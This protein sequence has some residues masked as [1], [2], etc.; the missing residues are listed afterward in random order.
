MTARRSPRPGAARR[1]ALAAAVALAVT[2]VVACAAIPTSGPVVDG[3][4]VSSPGKAVFVS[5]DAPRDGALPEQ[6]VRGFLAAQAQGASSSFD[7]ATMFLTPETAEEWSPLAQVA[8]L[9]GEPELEVDDSQLEEGVATVRATADVVGTVD[10]HGVYTEQVPGSTTE[11]VYGLVRDDAGQ[12]RVDTTDDGLAV[13]ATNFVQTYRATNLYFPTTDRQYLVPDERWFPSRNW[14]TLAVRE[15]LVGPVPWLAGAVT[16][17]VPEGTALSIESVTSDGSSPVEVPLTDAASETS[18]EDRAVLV[19]QLEASLGNPSPRDVQITVGGAPLGEGEES[20]LR[21]ASTPNDPVV[22]AGGQVT[23]IVG[24]ETAPLS[25]VEPLTGLEP[26]AL[27]FTGSSRETTFV[28]RDGSS[29][30]VTAPTAEA[31]PVVLL[32]GEDLLAPSVDRFG[33]VWSGPQVQSGTLQVTD[34]DARVTDVAAPWLDGRTVMSV[35]VAPDGARIAVVSASASGVQV[36]VAGVLRDEDGRPT[37]LSEPVRV[38]Q[39]LVAATQ[40]V[41]VDRTLLGVL[42][43]TSGDTEP[44]VHLVPVG[45]PTSEASALEDAVSLASGTGIGTMLLGTSDGSLYSAGSSSLWTRVATEVRLPTY[46]G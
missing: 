9:E 10:E 16:T 34:L 22:L 14:Q 39:P 27:A 33:L 13:S 21:A 40:V 2:P 23:S 1:A 19:S 35:R 8:V 32:E 36:H 46:P 5:A 12:W 11:L 45:G 38:G 7:V 28:V 20:T 4:E 6:I 17:V 3:E 44:I 18:P 29:R 25:S 15:T 30:L 31:A 24:R 42:G 37:E 41:W 26:T 43:R